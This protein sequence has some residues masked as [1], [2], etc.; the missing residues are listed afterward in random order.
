MATKVKTHKRKKKNGI[1]VVREHSRKDGK[2]TRKGAGAE[3]TQ[4]QVD[5]CDTSK[6]TTKQLK[7]G[8]SGKKGSAFAKKAKKELKKRGKDDEE[9]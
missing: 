3:Y 2:S 9:A 7:E 6:C 8:A 1:S 4:K 5:A